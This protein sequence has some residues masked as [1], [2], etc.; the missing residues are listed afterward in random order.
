MRPPASTSAASNTSPTTATASATYYDTN[1]LS[2]FVADGTNVIGF[3][4]F[5]RLVDWLELEAG[6]TT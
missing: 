2:N 3:D 6:I 5:A 4:P 1:A